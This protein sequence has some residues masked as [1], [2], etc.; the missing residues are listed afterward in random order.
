MTPVSKVPNFRENTHIPSSETTATTKA[1]NVG[2]QDDDLEDIDKPAPE[3]THERS[4][5]IRRWA[6]LPQHIA[7][8]KPEPKYLADRRPGLPPLYGHQ[9]AATSNPYSSTS[10]STGYAP[11]ISSTL[12]NNTGDVVVGSVTVPP[13]RTATASAYR[14][15][16]DGSTMP[17]GPGIAGFGPT[18]ATGVVQGQGQAGE[19]RRRPPPPPPKRK[20]KGG[21]GRS[22]K[23]IEIKGHV[24]GQAGGNT[25]QGAAK[26][27]A[28]GIPSTQ[29]I[30]TTEQP[31]QTGAV[32]GLADV[33]MAEAEASSSDDEE[34]GEGE[35]EGS[36][37]GEI[38]EGTGAAATNS[39]SAGAGAGM[40]G[41]VSGAL[42][43][44]VSIQPPSPDLLGNL[45]SE[46]QGMV[47]RGGA[48]GGPTG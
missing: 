45:E 43:P 25:V 37:E 20:K 41:A 28:T 4:F 13:D 27:L 48:N 46:I 30:T 26:E 47:E 9:A 12:T 35:D 23:R 2:D 31:Q 14:V 17:I 44:D 32:P 42:A 18:G 36:E 1:T 15:A 7:D 24:V 11:N 34:E 8:K 33:E 3:E 19:V 38:D 39:T 5:T 21:P 10:A 6:P 16:A 22:K 29:S 40:A